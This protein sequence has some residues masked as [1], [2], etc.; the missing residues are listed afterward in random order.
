MSKVND[1]GLE[2]LKR[3]SG[4]RKGEVVEFM[5]R[6]HPIT[7]LAST[8]ALAVVFMLPPIF[9]VAIMPAALPG[10]LYSPYRDIFFLLTTIY[11]GF[12]WI[13]AF[14][15]LADY[16]LDIVLVT[17]MRIMKVDQAGLFNRIVSELELD[18]IQ[19]ITSHID[20]PIRTLFNFGNL[21]IQTASEINRVK[22]MDIPHPVRVRRRIMELITAIDEHHH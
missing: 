13:I 5:L 7:L 8:I 1:D 22:P 17:N 9:Y 20:G 4:Q 12:F 2:V 14:M 21:E 3:F 10:L 16:Y 18:K 6:K 11:Y 15:E 19:D